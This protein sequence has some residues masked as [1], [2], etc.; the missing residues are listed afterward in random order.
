MASVLSMVVALAL[1]GMLEFT[2]KSQA[3]LSERTQADKIGRL[4]MARMIDELHSSC[5]GF[6]TTSLQGPSSAPTAP[7]ASTGPADLWFIS[8]YGSTTSG[9]AVISTVYEHDLHWVSTGKTSTGESVGTLTDYAF[10][11]VKG[12][13]PGTPAGRWEFPA[14]STANAKKRVLGKEDVIPPT[15]SGTSTLF[16]YYTL[17]PATGKFTLLTEKISTEAAANKIAKVSITLKAAAEPTKKGNTVNGGL[18][19]VASFSDG[20][21]LRLNPTE[22][23]ASAIDEPCT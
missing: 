22:T 21:N 13:G 4:S 12:S 6:G 3:R 9:N 16:Q 14:F 20:V 10:E 2:T 1:F 15:V 17:S 8:S 23:G 11:S 5:T 18:D 19:R 7:L